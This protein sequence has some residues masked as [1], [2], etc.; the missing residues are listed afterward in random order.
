MGKKIIFISLYIVAFLFSTKAQGIEYFFIT[1]PNQYISQLSSGQ[2]QLL[3]TNVREGKKDSSVVN[4]YGGKST[5]VRF[6]EKTEFIQVKLSSQGNFS[7][8]KF[9]MPDSSSLFAMGFWLCS[10]ACDGDLAFFHEK[11]MKEATIT[12]ILPTIHI[13]DFFNE[14]SLAANNLKKEQI[15]TKFDANFIHYELQENSDD[16]FVYFDNET[17]L[18]EVAFKRWKK[19]M[20][21]NRLI[22]KW[23]DGHFVKDEVSFSNK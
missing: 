5:L 8:K 23:E 15:D 4:N 6:N 9:T 11:S 19:M 16:I 18:G 21:G 2:R 1:L 14:D 20:K 22:L 12:E 3:I 13:S 7:A 17:Y 10:P